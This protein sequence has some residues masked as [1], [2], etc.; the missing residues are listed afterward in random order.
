M[1]D[2]Q[3]ILEASYQ[4]ILDFMS[5]EKWLEA[6][7]GCLEIL[8]FDPDN[9][10][11]IRL[12]NKIEKEVSKM[13]RK[14]IQQD[15]EKMKPLWKE[16]N[17]AEIVAY[18]Q[19]LEPYQADYPEL[20]EL[21]NKAQKAYDQQVYDEQEENVKKTI[22]TVEDLAAAQKFEEAVSEAEKIL[23]LKL[24]E[25]AVKKLLKKIRSQWIAAQIKEHNSLLTSEKYEDILLF[26]QNLRKIDSQSELLQKLIAKTK[27]D[28]QRYKI[29]G[30]KE[31]IYRGTEQIRTLY[32]L[33]KYEKALQAAQEILDID[34]T[35]REIQS[36]FK[37]AQKKSTQQI[38]KEVILQMLSAQKQYQTEYTQNKPAFHKI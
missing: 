38:E 16:K 17:Y 19:K 5:Q 30:K 29:E 1:R 2:T 24:H 12:K 22:K 35:N 26:Y 37:K 34:P 15:L 4:K 11:I 21:L 9:I 8:R 31:F 13:N 33:K 23:F 28:Y 32:Q 36:L 14:A 27:R 18:L 25:N 6:H 7:R 3:A 10:K 20:I